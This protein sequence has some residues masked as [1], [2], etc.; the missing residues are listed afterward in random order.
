MANVLLILDDSAEVLR[1]FRRCLSKRFDQT[2]TATNPAEAASILDGASPPV[3]HL[4]SDY[5]LGD[6]LPLG[7]EL[8]ARFRAAYPALKVAAIVTGSEIAPWVPSAGTDGIFQKP[9]EVR[10]LA[11]FLLQPRP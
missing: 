3:T 6:D 7:T 10:R 1:S 11:D 8:I 2:F 9:F 4:V 5:H